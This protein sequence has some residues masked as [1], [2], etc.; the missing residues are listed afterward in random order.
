M[1]E[2]R[3]TKNEERRTKIT[4]NKVQSNHERASILGYSGPFLWERVCHRTHATMANR[5]VSVQSFLGGLLDKEVR[6]SPL[7]DRHLHYS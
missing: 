7:R 3:R 1:T 6:K 2:E 5:A 4:P